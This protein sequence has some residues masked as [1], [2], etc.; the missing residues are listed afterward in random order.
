MSE[1]VPLYLGIDMGAT[2]IRYAIVDGDGGVRCSESSAL[3]DDVGARVEAPERILERFSAEVSGV[4]LAVAGTVR[5]G[6]LGWSAS[7]G[8]QGVDFRGRL[9]SRFGGAVAV[10]NDARAAGLAEALVG[11]GR[12]SPS[13]LSIT[14]GTGIGGA[15]VLDGR[16]LEGVGDA[17]EVGHIVIEPDGLEC[18]CGRRGCWERYVGGRALLEQARALKPGRAEALEDVLSE[19]ER[20]EPCSAALVDSAAERFALGLD[21]VCAVLAPEVIVL[22]GGVIARDGWVS[23][24]YISALDSMRWGAQ[25]V[26]RSSELGDA[27]GQIG[28]ALC[29]AKN[30]TRS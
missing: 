11:A 1:E 23:R 12:G 18:T 16:L 27:A 30:V 8:V 3:P 26:I 4:G 29:A 10:L 6:V 22:G 25:A 2:N 21:N 5:D 17:G 7:L 20:G 14:V 28:A 24:R 9:S 19:A 15:I 13:V